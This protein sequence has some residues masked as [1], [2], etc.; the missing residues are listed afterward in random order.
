[1]RKQELA[2]LFVQARI[3]NAYDLERREITSV[4]DSPTLNVDAGDVLIASNQADPYVHPSV[5]RVQLS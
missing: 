2:D 4:V 1:L 3:G 5:R